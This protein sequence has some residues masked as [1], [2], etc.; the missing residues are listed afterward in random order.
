M[1]K[2]TPIRHDK[3]HPIKLIETRRKT[4]TRMEM[5]DKSPKNLK[6]PTRV[7]QKFSKKYPKQKESAEVAK[8]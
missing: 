5:T 8:M 6:T 3:H 2:T 4:P 7:E 1:L